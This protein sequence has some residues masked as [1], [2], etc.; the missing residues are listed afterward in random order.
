MTEAKHDT[1]RSADQSIAGRIAHCYLHE[2]RTKMASGAALDRPHWSLVLLVPK[3]SQDAAQC[4]NYGRLAA[5]CM[6]ASS[7]AWGAAWPAGG[8]WP[9]L[10]GDVPFEQKPQ[11]GVTPLTHEQIIARNA[12]RI[13]CWHIEATSYLKTPVPVCVVKNG[14]AVDID[15]QTLHG[16][17]QYKSGDYGQ[18]LLNTYT[19]HTKTFGVNFGLQAV[20][21]THPGEAIGGGGGPREAS[22]MFG[23]VQGVAPAAAWLPMP[24]AAP[25]AAAPLAPPAPPAPPMPPPVPAAGA[26]AFPIPR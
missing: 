17:Q 14:V 8:K 3:L 19:F 13:G 12:W 6:E 9:I 24:P 25:V 5:M 23:A 1:K 18:V 21:F 26:P 20:Q 16:V 4:P 15:A 2:Q 7:Q 22:K 11:P 10:N